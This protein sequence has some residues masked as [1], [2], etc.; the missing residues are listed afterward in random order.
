M[1]RDP[2]VGLVL[3]GLSHT[4]SLPV[5]LP[6]RVA[7]PWRRAAQVI[8]DHIEECAPIIYTP[9]VGEVCL[10][11]SR[12]FRRAR[13]MYFSAEDKGNMHAMVYNW[14]AARPRGGRSALQ[15]PLSAR[16]TARRGAGR[17]NNRVDVIV[18]T[19][20]S[21]VLGLGDLGVQGMGISVGKLDLYVA[22][23]GIHPSY[24]LPVV[25][26]RACGSGRSAV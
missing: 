23:A 14:R 19:D 11:Y 15:H 2:L 4:H 9:T 26:P 6:W 12:L 13:G 3:P 17:D 5:L 8:I 22:G 18:V 24:V 16:L 20:G 10:Q 1:P 25:R 21:R 7:E